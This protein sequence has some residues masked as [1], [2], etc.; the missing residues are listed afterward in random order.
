LDKA[1]DAFSLDEESLRKTILKSYFGE[2]TAPLEPE[3]LMA[4]LRQL[5]SG[6]PGGETQPATY[7]FEVEPEVTVPVFFRSVEVERP[8]LAALIAEPLLAA[9]EERAAGRR[10][11]VAPNLSMFISALAGPLAL[12][13]DISESVAAALLAGF[14]IAVAR[15]GPSGARSLYREAMA[16]KPRP[17]VR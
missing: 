16:G 14:L 2:R 11:E 17:G 6:P 9:A 5:L 1:K 3:P 10:S 4:H 7:Y 13:A 12:K 8:G 15:L